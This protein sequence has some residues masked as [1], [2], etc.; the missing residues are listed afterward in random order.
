MLPERPRRQPEARFLRTQ[1]GCIPTPFSSKLTPSPQHPIFKASDLEDN[2][3]VALDR[4]GTKS[5]GLGRQASERWREL[6]QILADLNP[7]GP[8]DQDIWARAGGDPSRLK[9]SGTGRA[10]RFAALRTLKLGG[11]AWN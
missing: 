8:T 9:L 3:P 6:E 11:G 10:N 1:A 7:A 5:A 4:G 2:F